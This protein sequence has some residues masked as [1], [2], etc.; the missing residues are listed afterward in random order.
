MYPA[1][2]K[3]DPKFFLQYSSDYF[4]LEISDLL[5]IKFVKRYLE[6]QV[7]PWSNQMSINYMTYNEMREDL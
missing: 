7:L 5:K 3:L 6:G 1:D 2:G 4:P